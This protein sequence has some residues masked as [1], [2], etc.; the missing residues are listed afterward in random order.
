MLRADISAG[1][2]F[3]RAIKYLDGSATVKPEVS[4]YAGF[5]ILANF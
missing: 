4:P 3:N 5:N 1:A 2:V